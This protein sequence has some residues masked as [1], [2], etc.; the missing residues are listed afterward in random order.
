MRILYS[1]IIGQAEKELIILHGFL[2]MGDN[3]K[4]LAKKWASVGFRVHLIDQRNHGRSFWSEAFSYK[5]L[6]EDVVTYCD[7]HKLSEVY[8]LGHSMGGKTTMNLAILAPQLLKAFI[9][10]DIVPKKYVP[11]HQQLLNGLA[12]LDFTLISNRSE[13]SLRLSPFVKDEGTRMFLLRNLYWISPG[14]LG[15]RLNIEVLKNV[16]EVISD[17]LDAS[18]ISSIPCLFVKGEKSDYI[19]ETDYPIIQYHFPKAQNV[20][21]PNAGHWLHAENPIFFFDQ[22]NNWLQLQ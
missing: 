4:T 22:V 17:G 8:V 21:V 16:S 15:L 18:A 2:G 20:T 1:N 6:A 13:A 14:K 19:L 12:Q 11:H 9:V 7:H 3:W 5:L 10:A